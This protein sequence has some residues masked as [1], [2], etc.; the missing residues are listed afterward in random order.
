M[1]ETRPLFDRVLLTN[2]DGFDAPGLR[3][4]EQ[5]AAQ[6]A[7]EVWIVAPAE[8]QSGTSHSLSL[9]EPLRVHHKGERRFAV[10]GTPGDCV[11]IAVSHLMKDARPD[12]VLSGVNRGANLGTETVFSGTVGAA[13][14]SML[15]GV[16]AIALSQ[17]FTDRHAVPWNTALTHAPDVIRRLVAAGW[18]RDACLNVNFPAC[19]AQDVRGLKPTNQGAGTLQGVEIVS[20]RDPREIDYYWLKLARAPH[21]DAPETETV[22][23]G[24]GYVAVTPLKF[25]RTHDHA[26]AQLRSKLA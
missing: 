4:L 15:V 13:M 8:D 12:V 6:L 2:D 26:L 3:I 18:D 10:R 7:R 19:A 22:A 21:D 23:L 11:A 16:P 20:G 1:Q 5:V 17:A 9:H 14:T 25:E 24:E